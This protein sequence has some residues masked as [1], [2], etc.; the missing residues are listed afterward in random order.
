MRVRGESRLDDGFV[1][2]EFGGYRSPW[3][4][5]HWRGVQIAIEIAVPNP[6]VNRLSADAELSGQ[7]ALARALLQVVPQ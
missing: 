1:G 7:C 3:P 6:A 4:V 2:V 5:P